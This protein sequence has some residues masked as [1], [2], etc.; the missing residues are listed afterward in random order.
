MR[1]EAVRREIVGMKILEFNNLLFKEGHNVTVRRGVKWAIA[2]E[3]EFGFPIADA[4]QPYTANGLDR[5]IGFAENPTVK[6]KRFC[7][8]KDWEIEDEH[9]GACRT[10]D[11]LRRTMQQTYCDFSSTEI[12]TLIGFD[13]KRDFPVDDVI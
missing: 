1:E 3:G 11:G 5:I 8:I 9:D 6:V 2:E 13:Y 7:D 12:V 4:N 10:L